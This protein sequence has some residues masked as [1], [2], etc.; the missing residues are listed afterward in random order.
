[1]LFRKQR[2]TSPPPR[3]RP[4]PPPETFEDGQRRFLRELRD[5]NAKYV[6]SYQLTASLYCAQH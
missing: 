6:T 3:P 5:R 2:A 4:P 1:M